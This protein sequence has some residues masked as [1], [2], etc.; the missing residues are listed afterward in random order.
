MTDQGPNT[1]LVE[2]EL[3]KVKVRRVLSDRSIRQHLDNTEKIRV[4][5][6]CYLKISLFMPVV[7]PLFLPFT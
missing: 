4:K 7:K 5:L 1:V 3:V 6:V 2:I